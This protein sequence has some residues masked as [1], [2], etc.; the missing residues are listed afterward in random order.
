MAINTGVLKS[1]APQA[2]R[3]FIAA[4]K[5]RAAKFGITEA[6]NA[7]VR[8][9]GSVAII[10]GQP[11]P[12]SIAR[13]RLDLDEKIRIR[14]YQQVMDEVAYTWFNRFAAIRYMELHDY[15]DHGLRVLS[16]PAGAATPEIVEKAASVDFPGL[17][18]E[19]VVA[20]KLDGSKDEELYRLLLVAQCNALHAAMPFLFEKIN[21]ETELLLPD[22]LL[23]SDSIIRQMVDRVPETDWRHIEIIGWLYQFYISEKKDQVIGKVVKSEDIPAATQLFTPNWIVKYMV[24]NSLGAKWLDSNPASPLRHKMQ[25]FIAPNAQPANVQEQIETETPRSLDPQ[26]ITFLDPAS[27]SGHILVEAYDLFKEMYLERGYRSRE[28]PRLILEN[29]LYGLDID[30]RAAQMSAFALLMKAR[31]DD[32]NILS[33]IDPVRL[34]IV[35]IRDSKNVNF[36]EVLGLLSNSSDNGAEN[37]SSETGKN[38]ALTE[39]MRESI[40]QV[41]NLFAGAKTYGSLVKITKQ[42]AEILANLKNCLDKLVVNDLVGKSKLDLIISNLAPLLLQA[43][44][45]SNSY[46]AVAAN[47]PYMGSNYYCTLLKNFS[48]VNYPKSKN[49]LYSMFFERGIDFVAAKSGYVSFIAFQ[50]W[51]FLSSFEETR[52]LIYEAAPFTSLVHIGRGAFGSDFGTSAFS[53]RA[54][55]HS[56][57]QATYTRLFDRPGQ[58]HSNEVLSQSF[59]SNPRY[60]KSVSELTKVPT[61]P[62]AYWTSAA[63]LAAFGVGTFIGDAAKK[64]FSASGTDTFYRLWHEISLADFRPFGGEK[65]FPITKGGDYRRWYGNNDYVVNWEHNGSAVKAVVDVNGK[66]KSAVR[67]EGF[68]GQP[69]V[70][71]NDVS[72]SSFSCRLVDP[73]FLP[74]DAGPMIYGSESNLLYL[75]ALSSKVAEVFLQILCPTVHFGVGQ[76]A[77]FPIPTSVENFSQHTIEELVAIARHDWDERETSWNFGGQPLLSGKDNLAAELVSR[78]ATIANR[79]ERAR[80]LE[81]MNN[82]AFILA[83]N[84]SGEMDDQVLDKDLTLSVF[85]SNAEIKDLI[86][87]SV[88]CMMGR[89]GMGAPGVQYAGAGDEG[90]D[91]GAYGDFAPDN[92]GIVPITEGEWFLDDAA[93]KL[94]E[95]C[96]VAW[97]S[98]SR[99]ESART[100][101]Q[102]LG[103]KS[104]E[105]PVETIRRFFSRDFFKDHIRRYRRRPIYWLFSS[106]KEKAFE[107]LVYM[108]RY[109]G[110]TLARMRLEYVVPLQSLM[111]NRLDR[112]ASDFLSSS[113]SSVERKRIG[114]ERSKLLKQQEELRRFEEK[115][116]HYADQRIT[117][118]LDDGVKVNYGK[119]GDLLADVKVITGGGDE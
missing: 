105:V 61:A 14:G 3:E 26:T 79:R 39:D 9:E 30:E 97:P 86:S 108:H 32:R 4:V 51:M 114:N 93:N 100:L 96:R 43:E 64:G 7:E 23:H 99:G 22:N 118:N 83:Y 73:G 111:S 21:D 72:I 45:L 92:D 50:N 88:G 58:V 10:N 42:T 5:A 38:A 87:Y 115:L 119:F 102:A 55:L 98:E 110:S 17:K 76:I 109:N 8:T 49:D 94:Q 52:R 19:A 41:V 91:H 25:Y 74:T 67:N 85:D 20:L 112:L 54:G 47:P 66:P 6:G 2:R 113:L 90:F 36:A 59:F 82:A 35:A 78:S 117:L 33:T 89:F 62:I 63:T 1:Y 106:G 27:G 77:R 16:H 48:N 15:L 24:Q 34:S 103:P 104:G 18:R 12:I 84:L 56:D 70:S 68:Y 57:Y 107:A 40:T 28:I 53:A 75:G 80:T 46:D 11:F 116:H 65:W 101:A 13:Q 44:I 31:V 69:G 71:W 37:K 60:G 29:N 95:F 81:T